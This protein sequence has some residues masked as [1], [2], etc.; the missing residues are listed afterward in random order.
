M[1]TLTLKPQIYDRENQYCFSFWQLNAN[2]INQSII[3]KLTPTDCRLRP[4]LRVLEYCDYSLAESEK[5]RLE[6]K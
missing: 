1:T 6:K 4:D 3:Q 2:H 5:D